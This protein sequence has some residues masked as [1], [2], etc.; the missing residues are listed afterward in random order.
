[1]TMPGFT[2]ETS[3]GRTT[4]IYGSEAAFGGPASGAGPSTFATQAMRGSAAISSR[5]AAAA[6]RLIGRIGVGGGGGF[7]PPL[8]IEGAGPP[9]F[10]CNGESCDCYGV[11]DCIDLLAGTGLCGSN[12]SCWYDEMPRCVCLRA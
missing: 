4:R 2:A 7:A 3:L 12:V 8:P 5:R 1:M 6:V 10:S 9:G 11:D